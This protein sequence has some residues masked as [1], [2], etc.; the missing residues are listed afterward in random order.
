MVVG[1]VVNGFLTA[2]NVKQGKPGMVFVGVIG[3][4]AAALG[5]IFA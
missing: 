4:L 1:L 5:L 3:M 2:V